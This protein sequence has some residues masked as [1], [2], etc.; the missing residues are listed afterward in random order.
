M[1]PRPPVARDAPAEPWRPSTRYPSP[2]RSQRSQASASSSARLSRSTPSGWR[3]DGAC[4]GT[5][6]RACPSSPPWPR[7]WSGTASS[8][9]RSPGRL[10]LPSGRVEHTARAAR[11]S[12]ADRRR[13]RSRPGSAERSCCLLVEPWLGERLRIMRL[14]VMPCRRAARSPSFLRST[15]ELNLV[16][17]TRPTRRPARS[18]GRGARVTRRSRGVEVGSKSF[19]VAVLTGCR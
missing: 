6:S 11:P 8:P 18:R 13:R 19:M 3:S 9:R 1:A 5:G 16:F 17:S 7:P 15:S 4:P 10:A 12:V 14:T 2:L